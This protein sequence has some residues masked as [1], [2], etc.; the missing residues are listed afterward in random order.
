MNFSICI[1]TYLNLCFDKPSPLFL[2]CSSLHAVINNICIMHLLVHTARSNHT[3]T[4]TPPYHDNDNAYMVHYIPTKRSHTCTYYVYTHRHT[5]THNEI[6]S[7]LY[8]NHM[9]ML[10]A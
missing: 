3:N 2:S 5:A 7:T 10:Q 8:L 6:H 4:H 1:C 9:T